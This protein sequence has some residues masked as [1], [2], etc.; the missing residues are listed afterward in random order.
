MNDRT[1][2]FEKPFQPL[3]A[4]MT[5]A[6]LLERNQQIKHEVLRIVDD[7]ALRKWAVEQAVK[8]PVSETKDMTQFFY[9]FITNKEHANG[10]TS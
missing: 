6:Q 9:D 1:G 4:K 3:P 10:K 8:L 7:I 5:G 2:N